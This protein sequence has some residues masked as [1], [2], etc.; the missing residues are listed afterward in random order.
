MKRLLLPLLILHGC[1][2]GTPAT[3][4][5]IFEEDV[6]V[7]PRTTLT[8]DSDVLEYVHNFEERGHLKVVDVPVFFVSEQDDSLVP[9]GS[10]TVGLCMKWHLDENGKVKRNFNQV[11]LLSSWWYDASDP[12][13]QELIDHELGHCV[14]NREHISDKDVDGFPTSVM[15]PFVFSEPQLDHYTARLT[16][17][18]TELFR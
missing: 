5:T 4:Y 3:D 11:T 17:Y 16:E 12:A 6:D 18:T 14:L 9:E 2:V 15:Y 8:T 1:G 7:D 10:R 13:R